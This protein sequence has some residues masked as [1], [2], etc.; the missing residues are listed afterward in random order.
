MKSFLCEKCGYSTDHKGDYNKHINKKK[1]CIEVM[2]NSYNT[3]VEGVLDTENEPRLN[4][5]YKLKYKAVKQERDDLKLELEKIKMQIEMQRVTFE[6][7][8]LKLKAEHQAEMIEVLKTQ[9]PNQPI[10]EQP[11]EPKPTIIK[12][13]R[14][15]DTKLRIETEHVNALPLNVVINDLD[16]SVYDINTICRGSGSSETEKFSNGVSNCLVSKL[17][18]Y[19]SKSNLPMSILCSD[20][21]R[22]VLHFK[23]QKYKLEKVEGEHISRH[24]LSMYGFNPNDYERDS[25]GLYIMYKEVQVFEKDAD[26]KLIDEWVKEDVASEYSGLSRLIKDFVRRVEKF[27]RDGYVLKHDDNTENLK[28]LTTSFNQD[29]I[30]KIA[31]RMCNSLYIGDETE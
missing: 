26:G 18:K 24:D 6:C 11:V 8:K 4:K 5:D 25:K 15:N 22:K 7:E 29:I 14:F 13:T 16:Y 30:N 1:P 19:A 10:I 2:D 20:T 27:T 9:K 21:T 28:I 23:Q 17:K 31:S 12:A 3:V